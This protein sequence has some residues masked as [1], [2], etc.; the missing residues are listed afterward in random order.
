MIQKKTLA[1]RHTAKTILGRMLKKYLNSQ[2]QNHLNILDEVQEALQGAIIEDRHKRLI[3]KY[4]ML[5][6]VGQVFGLPT[7]KSILDNFGINSSTLSKNY[8]LIHKKLKGKE[9]NYLVMNLFSSAFEKILTE[10]FREMVSKDPSIFSKI[11]VTA[12]LDD[13][14]FRCWLKKLDP[15][16]AK[17]YGY[18]F[19]GQFGRTVTGFQVVTFGISVGNV[20]FPLYAEFVSKNDSDETKH[21]VAVR[22]INRWKKFN[23]ELI[24]NEIN[25]PELFLSCDNGYDNTSILEAWGDKVLSVPQKRNKITVN[26]KS[27]KIE[28]YINK[29]YLPKEAKHKESQPDT[30]FEL[31]IRAEYHCRGKEVVLLFFRFSGSSTVS[32]VYCTDTNAMKKTIR[33]NWFRRTYIEQF[34]KITKHVLQIQEQRAQ[35]K[36]RFE[37]NLGVT[38]FLAL[39]VQLLIK[40]LRKKCTFFAHHGFIR[41]KRILMNHAGIRSYFSQCLNDL[42]Q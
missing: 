32:V 38:M 12:V 21:G 16:T 39:H 1:K 25:I 37:F 31:R 35:E 17:Y 30:P 42:L 6:F 13:T 34:F 26:G 36:S 7:L 27:Y 22:L 11:V 20:F 2:F 3:S 4:T 9:F 14:V 24:N 28:D 8:S 23:N 33:R 40:W 10:E 15:E 19:S 29:Y 18:F 5:F 41:L